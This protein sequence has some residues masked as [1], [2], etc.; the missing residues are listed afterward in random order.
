M[1]EQDLHKLQETIEKEVQRLKAEI[2]RLEV[3]VQP[4]AP[5]NAIGRLSRLDNMVNQEISTHSLG[6]ARTRLVK[7]QWMLEHMEDT[8]FGVCEDCGDVI[9]VARLLAVPESPFCVE[10]A[11]DAS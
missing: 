7:L 2:K 9:P 10:C 1:N 11:E 4:V 5:D 6:V 3:L 8:E